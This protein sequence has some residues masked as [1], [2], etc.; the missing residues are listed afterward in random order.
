MSYPLITSWHAAPRRWFTLTRRFGPLSFSTV[1]YW[2]K[3]LD[4]RSQFCTRLLAA[5]FL[6]AQRE[7]GPPL[8]VRVGFSPRGWGFP[9]PAVT[10][11]ASHSPLTS[12]SLI[13]KPANTS[14]GSLPTFPMAGV[15]S[16]P[17]NRLKRMP[18]PV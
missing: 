14:R 3:L 6:G 17:A 11:S 18:A 7:Q 2:G 4:S 13:S 12:S 8:G 15:S 16:A 10:L 5:P 1:H 9:P